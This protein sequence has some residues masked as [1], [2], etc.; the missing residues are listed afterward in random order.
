MGDHACPPSPQFFFLFLFSFLMFQLTASSPVTT[1]FL[2]ALYLLAA[3]TPNLNTRIILSVAVTRGTF[4]FL[5]LRWD[6]CHGLVG[7]CLY[8]WCSPAMDEWVSIISILESDSWLRF[9]RT[10]FRSSRIFLRYWRLVCKEQFD[11]TEL[12]HF[13]VT[14][15]KFLVIST[16]LLHLTFPR[17]VVTTK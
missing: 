3:K 2:P 16:I 7:V 9:C 6:Y 13:A 17:C 1:N 4:Y 14:S 12:K 5:R 10:P 8:W 11:S 15:T